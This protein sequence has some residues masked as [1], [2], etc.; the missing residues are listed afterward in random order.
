MFRGVSAV[1]AAVGICTAVA[2]P[3]IATVAHPARPS[4]SHEQ[5]LMNWQLPRLQFERR[6]PPHHHNH[7]HAVHHRHHRARASRSSHRVAL[8]GSPQTIAHA[9]LLRSGWAEN[10]WSCLDTLWTRE[11]GWETYASNGGSGAY[12]I[13]QALPA[14]KMASAGPDWRTNPVTQ[15]R[16]G[17]SYIRSVYGTPCAALQH[18]SAYGYY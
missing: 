16:W 10:E 1:L 6:T 9:M 13:P 18:S 4:G 3:A 14:S 7:H 11:S 15:I 8:T 5:A 17:L 2:A 12:G